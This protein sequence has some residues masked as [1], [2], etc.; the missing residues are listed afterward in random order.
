MTITQT[1]EITEDRRITIPSEVPT[2]ATI[3]TFTP[4]SQKTT[5]PKETTA[6]QKVE[7][8]EEQ[9][10]REREYINLH[11]ERLNK[12]AMDVLSY[13]WPGFNEEKLQQLI[14]INRQAAELNEE[15]EDIPLVRGTKL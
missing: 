7:L 9:R 12:E 4:A 11:A 6:P 14:A 5:A 10:Q 15:M 3:I 8:T 2:G 1:V 13:Q